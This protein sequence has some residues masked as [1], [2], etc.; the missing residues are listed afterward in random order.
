[1]GIYFISITCLIAAILGITG[2]ILYKRQIVSICRQIKF[3]NENDSNILIT[4]DLS[5][6]EVNELVDTLNGMI[7]KSRMEKL[8]IEKKD[9][10]LKEAITNI[11]HDIRTP[12]TSLNG[13][14][15]L[16]EETD[17]TEEKNRY[18]GVIKE[19]IACLKDMLEQ[20]FTYVKLQNGEYE[21][22]LEEFDLNKELCNTLV[23]FYEEFKKKNIEPKIQIPEEVVNVR[24]NKMAVHRIFENIIKNSVEHGE[25]YFDFV[26]KV[27]KDKICITVKNDV[28]NGEDIDIEKIFERFYKAD[29]SRSQIST[30]LGLAIAHDMVCKMGGKIQAE[31]WDG[32]FKIEVVFPG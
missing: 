27:Y 32:I 28:K 23:G 14:F 7:K 2:V 16:L 24:L 4:R 30:G 31:I 1:M 15:E 20:L 11:S 21:F 22:E 29:K 18:Y 19:R 17:D 9:I 8:K 26:V 5:S 25:K 12:L 6:K 10:R 3:I 13:Y